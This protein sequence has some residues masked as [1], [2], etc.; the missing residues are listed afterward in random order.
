MDRMLEAAQGNHLPE[1]NLD[2]IGIKLHRN[3]SVTV[4]SRLELALGE[5]SADSELDTRDKTTVNYIR[6]ESSELGQ[7]DA[8]HY[9]T[10]LRKE[11]Q[12]MIL[13]NNGMW[14]S[15][16][17]DKDRKTGEL[18]SVDVLLSKNNARPTVGG[19]N[20]R[21]PSNDIANLAPGTGGGGNQTF[22]IE[23]LVVRVPNPEIFLQPPQ[24]AVS[25]K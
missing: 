10:V 25:E 24:Q 11:Q 18:V 21:G 12:F 15:A 14:L 16:P 8:N 9:K 2:E 7:R 6:I 3:A 5:P 20:Q 23:I 22:V 19:N 1:S 17:V 13:N 4:D